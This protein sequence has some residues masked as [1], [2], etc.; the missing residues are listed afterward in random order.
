[1]ARV[2]CNVEAVNPPITQSSPSIT[3]PLASKRGCG[4]GAPSLQ[5]NTVSS[6]ASASPLTPVSGLTLDAA[7]SPPPSR[8]RAPDPH[9]TLQVANVT[10]ANQARCATSAS[11]HQSVPAR[12]LVL[13]R[14]G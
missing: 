8:D 7:S 14:P 4:Q 11:V 1:M 13:Q 9:P 5:V 6:P 12:T 3:A 10:A 2:T